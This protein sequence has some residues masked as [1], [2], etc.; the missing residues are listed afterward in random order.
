MG[1]ST[2]IHGHSKR[3]GVS[4]TGSVSKLVVVFTV[5]TLSSNAETAC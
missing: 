3:D 5:V 2:V 1:I 4:K